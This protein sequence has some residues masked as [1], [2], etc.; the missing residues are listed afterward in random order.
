M[1]EHGTIGAVQ[2]ANLRRPSEVVEEGNS[3]GWSSSDS[4][5]DDDTTDLLA[6]SRPTSDEGNDAGADPKED[7]TTDPSAP[8]ELAG[9]GANDADVH[10]Q[11]SEGAVAEP[12]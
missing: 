8:S 10:T 4:L 2:V 3:D 12:S 1:G 11:D 5:P 6:Q 7:E 9:D